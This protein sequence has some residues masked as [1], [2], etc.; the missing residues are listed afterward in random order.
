MSSWG[1]GH[2][3]QLCRGSDKKHPH[4]AGWWRWVVDQASGV[5]QTRAGSARRQLPP[6]LDTTPKDRLFRE[7]S[8]Q[9]G[10]WRPPSPGG[11]L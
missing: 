3:G 7:V 9:T 5:P 4:W 10:P 8:E 1:P 2:P 6:D 11:H